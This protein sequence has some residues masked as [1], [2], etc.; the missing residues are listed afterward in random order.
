VTKP[1]LRQA[2]LVALVTALLVYGVT[3]AIVR[4][5]I[6]RPPPPTVAETKPFGPALTQHL[7]FVVIDG[8]RYDFAIDP[9]RMPRIAERMRRHRSAE[10]WASRVSMMSSAVLTYG[11]GQR[12][13]VDQIVNN[14]MGHAVAYENIVENARKSGLFSSATGDHA[15]FRYYPKAFD[16]E[17]PD[18]EGVAIDVD[19]N[20][21]IFKAAYEFLKHPRRP[22]LYVAHFVTPDHQAHAYGSFSAR[23]RAHLLAFD[24]RIDALLRAFP[25]DTTVIVTSDHG[26]TD[27]GTHGS[28]TPVQRRSPIFAYGPGIAPP[29]PGPS[30]PLDQ[31]DLPDTFAALLGI[32]PPAHGRGHLLSAWLRLPDE[33]RADI[34]CQSLARLTTY[35]STALDTATLRATGAASACSGGS[36]KERVTRAAAAAD[37]IDDALDAAT[38]GGARFAWLVPLLALG[39]ALLMTLAIFGR[40]SVVLARELAGA[41]AAATAILFASTWVVQHTELLPGFWPNFTLIAA[42]VVA[43]AAL[44]AGAF[45]MRRVVDRLGSAPLL[46]SALALG[47][48]V[49]TPTR[50]TQ[51]ESFVLLLLFAALAIATDSVRTD[52]RDGDE[53]Q[54][55]RRTRWTRSAV[56]VLLLACLAP[57]GFMAHGY[58]P[59]LLASGEAPLLIVG[60]AAILAFTVSRRRGAEGRDAIAIALSGVFAMAC[61]V[62]RHL[63]PPAV[64]VATWCAAPV[65]A[66]LAFRRGNRSVGEL[67][68]LASFTWVSRDIEIPL[69]LASAVLA[70]RM[71]EA[72]AR[73]RSTT[74]A[75]PRGLVV[76]A[77]AFLF[78]LGFV[79][80]IAIQQGVDF[81]HFDWGAGAFRDPKAPLLRIGIAIVFKHAVAFGMVLHAFFSALT[82]ALRAWAARGLL[83]V[84]LWRVAALVLTLHICR[85]SFWT[86]FRVIGDV[87]HALMAASVAALSVVGLALFDRSAPSPEHAPLRLQ[88]SEGAAGEG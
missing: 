8:L 78:V 23:Y 68:V 32:A 43:N 85:A 18:P 72:F 52:E 61:L 56:L 36:S 76:L 67:F 47:T 86:T 79:Q 62:G 77:V 33:Q 54:Q 65:G 31:V 22:N 64:C 42:Y 15:W 28:D 4:V 81:M 44:I 75:S 66:L 84:E 74:D 39:G 88:G 25:D 35:A 87:P 26:A 38:V 69:L 20:D 50:T 59:P 2:L 1:R 24:E 57:S 46:A 27:T 12:G 49:A 71:G 11:T 10:I 37:A 40:R 41:C 13:D 5:V 34:A 70:E 82:P 7:A 30:L 45:R 29:S 19:Y 63:A 58:V 55:S 83:V 17:H 9:A 3:L 14:E 16:L 21:E 60:C 80:R 51:A 6:P 73:V 48:L 53:T